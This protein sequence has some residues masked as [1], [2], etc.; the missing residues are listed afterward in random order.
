MPGLRPPGQGREAP[1]VVAGVTRGEYAQAPG[2]AAE[3]PQTETIEK[4]EARA[5]QRKAR[6]LPLSGRPRHPLKEPLRSPSGECAGLW[7]RTLVASPFP[8]PTRTATGQ[9]A[10]A[11]AVVARL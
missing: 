10:M 7:A 11:G 5:E 9:I 6:T 8:A 2:Q 1:G 3:N 4:R